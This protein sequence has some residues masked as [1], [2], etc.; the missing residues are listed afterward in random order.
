MEIEY[1]LTVEDLAAFARF[2]LK[3]GPRLK[4][5]P[6]ARLVGYGLGLV[7]VL[8]AGFA[9]WLRSRADYQWSAGFCAGIIAG[10]LLTVVVLA[11]LNRRFV[12]HNTIRLFEREESSWYLAGRRLKINPDS[13]ESTNEF[14]QLRLMWSAIC[15]IES[16]ANHAF[17]YTTLNQAHVIPRRA[18][19]D[20]KHFEEF[21]DLACRYH[22][23]LRRR[24][25]ISEDILDAL[26]AEQMGITQR[27]PS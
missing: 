1:D 16:T 8:L 20:P 9:G 23:G 7:L 19:R 10:F 5:H 6:R 13:F 3:H 2:H 15:R 21:V 27:P 11:A 12:V 25:P 22:Q 14:Q 4:P 24:Q 26:P 17:F 18:F